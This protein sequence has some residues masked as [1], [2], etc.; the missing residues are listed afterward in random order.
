MAVVYDLAAASAVRF[1]RHASPAQVEAALD[2]LRQL[3][4]GIRERRK[5]G[6]MVEHRE[7][8]KLAALD[9]IGK[10]LLADC[11]GTTVPV[12]LSA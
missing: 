2:D 10:A 5:A 4:A 11:Q 6:E 7:Q 9:A 3:A 8:A 1:L 12:V